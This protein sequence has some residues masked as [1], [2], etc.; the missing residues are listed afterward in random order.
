MGRGVGLF[1]GLVLVWA[2]CCCMSVAAYGLGDGRVYEMV[3]PVYKG[4]YGAALAAVAPN[5]ESVAF[6]S[7]GVFAGVPWDGVDNFYVAR[8]GPTGWSTT[9]LQPP[10]GLTQDFSTTLEYT[11]GAEALGPSKGSVQYRPTEQELLLHGTGTPDT[12][13]NWGVFGGIVLKPVDGGITSAVTVGA[14]G[15]L[16]HVVLGLAGSPFLREAVNTNNQ[17]YDVSRGCDGEPSLRLVGVKNKSGAHNEPEVFNP[18]CDVELG[19]GN[20]YGTASE[21]SNF[22]SISADGREM[23]FTT[24]VETGSNC[25]GVHQLFVR[26]DGARTLEVSRPLEAKK[27]FGGCVAKGVPGEVPCEGAA[28]RASAY[29]KGADELGTR[30]FFTTTAQLLGEDKDEKNDLY[31][32][33]IE[34]PGGEAQGCEPAQREVTSLAQV[35]HDPNAGEPAEVQGVV[36]IASDGSRV[37]FVAHGVLSEGANAE[38]DAPVKGAENLYVYERDERYPAGHVTFVADLCSGPRLSGEAEDARCPTDLNEV[39]D[40]SLWTQ[41]GEAQ[42]TPDGRFLAFSSYGRLLKSDTDNAK[43]V[44]RYDAVTGVLDRVSLGEAGYHSNGNRNDSETESADATIQLGGLG[45]DGTAVSQQH[46]M[47]THEISEDG[48]RILF[49]S[50]EPLS[51]AAINHLANVYE[52]HKEPA[53]SEGEVSLISSGSSVFKDG[54]AVIT[55]SGRDVFFQTFQGLVPRDTEGESDIYDARLEESGPPPPSE[56]REPCPAGDACLGPLS[57]P[58][59]LLVPGS[60]SQAPGQN[61]AAPVSTT[62]VKPK[63][64]SKPAKCKR[65][66][67]KKKGK[68]VKKPKK[69]AKGK[70]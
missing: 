60:V 5:G 10:F 37:Y 40:T 14:S 15:D 68:C 66:Y 56:E 44:Y 29:F 62:T 50:A 55:P 70:K 69:S 65:G 67:V 46:E 19:I 51:P 18:N 53:W 63:P 43:D 41:S 48:S 42:S 16:C 32:A 58:A 30:V 21:T 24:N 20:I 57:N 49:T 11:L 28:G 23:F 1:C 25:G 8:R 13:A 35:S 4:G 36:R 31:M 52:W 27:S 59:P 34:C 33:M 7:L 3:S 54:P 47:G 64:K 2:V 45:G 38:G 26:L 61:F 9:G 22:N 12:A 17:L 6:D 39:N